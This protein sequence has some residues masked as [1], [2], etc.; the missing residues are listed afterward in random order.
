M[1]KKLKSDKYNRNFTKRS[2]H[3]FITY[4]SVLLRMRNVLDE[5]VVNR[6]TLHDKSFFSE[7][8]PFVRLCGNIL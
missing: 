1:K 8:L 3:I 2:V 5:I 4:H 7:I 6:Y